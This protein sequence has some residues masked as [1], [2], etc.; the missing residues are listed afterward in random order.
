[1]NNQTPAPFFIQEGEPL[2][3]LSTDRSLRDSLLDPELYSVIH[4]Y[5]IDHEDENGNYDY[6]GVS[7]IGMVYL[8]I[9]R[10]A[11]SR[12][13]NT[14]AEYVRE[15]LHFLRHLVE[16]GINDIRILKRG[17][18][19]VY[20]RWLSNQYPKTKTQAKKI[21]IINAFL[22]WCYKEGYLKR[23]LSRGLTMVKLDK[24][25]IPDREIDEATLQRAIDFYK[26]DPKFLSL[27]VLLSTTGLR[28]NEII[29]PK[30]KDLYYDSV[31][32]KHYLRTQT[33]RD[34]VRHAPIKNY[35]LQVLIEYRRR[36][37]LN[38]DLNPNDESPFYPNRVGKHYLLTSLSA[39]VTRKMAAANLRT[40]NDEKATAHFMRHYFA[41]S[42][43]QNGATTDR[44][45]KTLGHSSSKVTEENYLHR[46]LKKDFD[47]SDFVE[48]A[49]FKSDFQ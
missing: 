35:V 16:T 32:E 34:G 23:D 41:R 24:K 20:Q 18:L 44:I 27:L 28:L 22:S 39:I 4:P 38:V 9:H 26:H 2:S 42:A 33:K 30:W 10:K 13:R 43:F 47:V 48:L 49:G 31:R 36:L 6:S 21:T 14:R 46:E 29:T 8:Y 1:M 40:T 11:G 17:Q 12:K 45:A 19:E 15:L 5:L 37:G 7:N 25:Q 3:T